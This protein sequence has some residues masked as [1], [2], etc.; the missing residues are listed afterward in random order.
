MYK[1]NL[2]LNTSNFIHSAAEAFPTIPVHS[3]A[4]GQVV[5]GHLYVNST[6]TFM[7]YPIN[8]IGLAQID[9]IKDILQIEPATVNGAEFNYTIYY[10]IEAKSYLVTFTAKSTGIT[11]ISVLINGQHIA[12][13]PFAVSVIGI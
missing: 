8:S 10:D 12:G 11:S 4:S 5:S 2:Y 9:N 7:V 13:S 3:T 6:A 1:V